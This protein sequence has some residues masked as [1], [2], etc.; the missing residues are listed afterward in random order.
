[1]DTDETVTTSDPVGSLERAVVIGTLPVAEGGLPSFIALV[2]VMPREFE[3]P[4]FPP[5]MDQ[6]ALTFSP[7]ILIARTNEVV[8]FWNSD[9][10]LHNVRVFDALTR[11]PS[12]NVAIPTG[13]TYEHTFT[14][15]AFYEVGCDIHPGMAAIVFST[16]TPYAVQADRDGGFELHDVVPGTYT[17]TVYAGAEAIERVV[18]VVG[19]RTELAFD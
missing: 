17:A 1:M 8:Q 9:A 10:E 2:P 4:E 14:K 3:P 12:F 6:V 16:S 18:D 5:S 11:D 15:D 13:G 7:E 19:P